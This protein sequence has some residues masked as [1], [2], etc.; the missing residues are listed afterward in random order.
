[1]IGRVRSACRWAALSVGLGL[2]F[3][4]SCAAENLF[5]V[6]LL[7]ADPIQVNG[8]KLSA[9]GVYS[10]PVAVGDEISTVFGGAA[11][12]LP[13]GSVANIAKASRVRLTREDGR[14]RLTLIEGSLE[15]SI[16]PGSRLEVATPVENARNRGA[17]GSVD[18]DARGA[19]WRP[20]CS[21]LAASA[22]QLPRSLPLLGAT[23]SA[24]PAPAK[25]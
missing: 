10:W 11:L 7:A 15:Y 8:R 4:G 3:D 19:S 25:K 6:S 14:L 22:K 12:S 2:A 16:A 18:V 21:V 23:S 24:A 17:C 20:G 9:A 13:D 5:P 1:M